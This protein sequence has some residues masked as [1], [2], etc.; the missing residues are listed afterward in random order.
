MKT[1][2]LYATACNAKPGKKF[3]AYILD[4]FLSV[5]LTLSF[6]GI[7]EWIMNAT[8][9]VTERKSQLNE[10]VEQMHQM[11]LSSHIGKENE[12]GQL[13]SQ[14]QYVLDYIKGSVYQSLIRNGEKTISKTTYKDV[15]MISEKNDGVFLYFVSFKVENKSSFLAESKNESGF[16]YYRKEL[17]ENSSSDFFV[18]EGYPY[19]TYECAKSIDSYFRDPDYS[20][21][22]TNY[23][24]LDSSYRK[25]LEKGISDIQR[26]YQPYLDLN[27]KY[28]EETK[29]LYSVK[30]C[31][32]LLSYFLSICI[33]YLMLPLLLKDGRT[34]SF[35]ALGF[36][37][38]DK[39]GNEPSFYNV[40]IRFCMALIECVSTVFFSGLVFFASSSIGWLGEPLIGNISFLSLSLFSMIFALFSFLLSLVLSNTHQS[41]SEW[42]AMEL[43]KDSKVFTA[44]KKELMKNE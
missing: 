38:T 17:F 37:V 19:L 40:L 6:F 9:Y 39:E 10:T 15:E 2:S 27:D 8:P 20:I 42:I 30:N 26:F 32:V 43:V 18:E 28:Q 4:F 16:D 29:S 34:I 25:L 41:L 13:L 11:V 36:S 24:R 12:N 1:Q 22:K 31:E 7:A 33:L 35:K 23:Q 3:A 14:N 44:P 5:V 21:G